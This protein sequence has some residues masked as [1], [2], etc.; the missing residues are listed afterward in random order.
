MK[1]SVAQFLPTLALLLVSSPVLAQPDPTSGASQANGAR[2]IGEFSTAKYFWQQTDVA[3]KLIATG[4]RGIVVAIQPYLETDDRRRRCNAAFV[5]AGLGDERGPVILISELEDTVP[6]SRAIEPDDIRGHPSPES[7]A[8]QQVRS[9]RYF[10]ALLLG[11]LREQSAV[12]ALVAATRDKSINYVAAISLG[13]IGDARSIPALREMATAF[14]EERV[15]AGYGLAA[16]GAPDGFDILE[17]VALSDPQ[18]VQRRHAVEL[19]G[20]TAD[21][22][23]VPIL[24]RVLK[25]EHPNVRVSTVRSL[26]EIGDPA[27]LPA[28]RAALGDGEVT[29]VNAPT[30]VAA[31]AEKAIEAIE[32]KHH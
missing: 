25:D 26:A 21:R 6:G 15:F 5:L 19:L 9:D 27:A 22:R 1:R 3:R 18:W 23:A 28:L 31:E 20:K 2:L 12:P 32:A 16:L 7:V 13:E 11:E 14:P 24:L 4:D 8:I 17:D 10:A 29:P 30:T